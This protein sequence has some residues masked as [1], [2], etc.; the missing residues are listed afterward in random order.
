MT[1][2]WGAARFAVAMVLCAL[3]LAIGPSTASAQSEDEK[4]AKGLVESFLVAL[5]DGD[6]DALPDM[7]VSDANIGTASLRD[8]SWV[9]ATITFQEWLSSLRE[10]A[11]WNRFREP[12]S[13]YTIHVE[14]SMMAFV[15]ADATLI[16]DGQARSRNIDYFTLVREDGAWKFL[17]ASYVAKPIESE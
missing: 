12:V 1:N 3:S 14:D 6:L 9:T 17:S 7:F 10:R 16:R 15:R 13:K 8:G 5:G 4:A 11:T 2:T